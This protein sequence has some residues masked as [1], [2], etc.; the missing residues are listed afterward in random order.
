[1]ED[2]KVEAPKE[3]DKYE[4][5]SA[6]RTLIEAR[7]IKGNSKL[8]EKV[9]EY[10][11][12]HKAAIEEMGGDDSEEKPAASVKELREKSTKMAENKRDEK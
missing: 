4:I 3:I 9:R 7:K 10:A 6:F 1:M 8:M 5:E 11:E 2:A 12:E